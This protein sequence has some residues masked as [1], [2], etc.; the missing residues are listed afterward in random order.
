MKTVSAKLLCNRLGLP[1]I[2]VPYCC[3]GILDFLQS[4]E[5]ECVILIDEAEKT[6]KDTQEHDYGE[7]LLKLIDGVYNRA[8]K[9]YI[10]TT[11]RLTINENLIGRPGRIRYIKEFGNLTEKAV[12]DYIDDNLLI[13]EKKSDILKTVDLL[14]IST[15]DILRS[16][17]DEVNIQGE[18]PEDSDLNIPKASHVFKVLMFPSD[19]D[20][21][22]M[23][24]IKKFIT[25][26]YKSGKLLAWLE[27]KTSGLPK[28]LINLG[29]VDD[30]CYDSEDETV[31]EGSGD[32][33]P[34]RAWFNNQFGSWETKITST[35]SSLYKGND[36]NW[37]TVLDEPDGGGFVTLSGKNYYGGSSANEPRIALLLNK[38]NS[39]SLYRGGLVF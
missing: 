13:P 14:E 33:K 18:I 36:T 39:P 19:I 10:L 7:V 26:L 30:E 4:I 32:L 15:I 22:I 2:V 38:K 5:Y 16:I 3:T 21:D 27:E 35:W 23:D 29:Q 25:P 20:E 12:N 28:E 9:L 31:E 11:N 17:V 37:G 8:R 1:V 34:N 24:G 6:F